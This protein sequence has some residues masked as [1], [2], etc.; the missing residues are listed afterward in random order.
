MILLEVS[1]PRAIYRGE[2]KMTNIELIMAIV[3]ILG[4]FLLFAAAFRKQTPMLKNLN[5]VWAGVIGVLLI[6]PGFFY[7][8]MPMMP[9][10]SSDINVDVEVPDTTPPSQ[11]LQYPEF[12]VTPSAVVV[13]Y[14]S[15]TTLN[16]GKTMFTVPALARTVTHAITHLDNT[17][18]W[19]DP[20][21]Q[22]DIIPVPY[23]GADADDLATIYFTVSNYDARIDA[24]DDTYR[25]ITKSSGEYQVIWT[26]GSSTWYVEGSK[27]MLLTGNATIY[28][29][30]DVNQGGMSRMDINDPI[31]LTVTFY[32]GDWSWSKSYTVSFEVQIQRTA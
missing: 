1:Y 8:V 15:D 2:D 21:L 20:R 32:N 30:F 11:I 14:N 25:L 7:G 16:S 19:A 22:F 4:L 28:L 6:I 13:T 31:D 26:E 23:T 5:P 29:D 10:M 12:D 17:T 27:T 24:D 9:E 18:A 3:F